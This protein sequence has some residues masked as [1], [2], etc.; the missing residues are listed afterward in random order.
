[1]KVAILGGGNTGCCMAADFTL[2][3]FDVIL[4]EE[5][6]YWHEHIN[7]IIE[8]NCEIEVIGRDL[9]GKARIH[10][11]TDSLEEA[12]KNA[13]IIFVSMIISRHQWLIERIVPLIDDEK[14]IIFSAGNF[15]SIRLRN[16]LGNE[17]NAVTGEMMGNIFPCRMIDRKTALIALPLVS[18][19]VAAFPS[20]DNQR[21]IK[22]VSPFF[23]CKEAKNV[24]EA[25]LNAPN[26]VIHLASSLLN[27][28]A[29]EKNPDFKLYEEGLTPS[30]IA[31]QVEVEKEKA[32]IMN[33]MGYIMINHTDFMK[34]LAQYDKYP[35]FDYFRSLKGPDSAKHR[36]ISE[37]GPGG[38]SVMISLAD[39]IGVEVPLMK[40]LITVA[41]AISGTDFSATGLTLEDLGIPGD[42]PEEINEYLHTGSKSMHENKSF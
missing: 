33:K 37:D 15:A 41:S 11:I 18:K 8:N 31:C 2:R 5:R 34:Q 24:F 12:V 4:Y 26:L 3:G 25:S 40:S 38:V 13:T 22:A 28:G 7:G 9:T 10:G 19:L 36:Y 1:M 29:I 6:K 16:A 23:A 20:V 32:A 35:E 39:R 30:V 21:L 42:T 17:S 27:L 14:T